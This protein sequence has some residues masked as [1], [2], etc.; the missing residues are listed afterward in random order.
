MAGRVVLLAFP[1]NWE[2]I[3]ENK[4]KRIRK[5]KEKADGKE[6]RAPKADK[7]LR[8]FLLSPFKRIKGRT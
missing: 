6:Q 4:T 1:S 3:D 5:L 7:I 8:P 2:K